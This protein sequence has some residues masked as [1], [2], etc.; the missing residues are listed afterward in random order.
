V[1]IAAILG[2]IAYT[3][4]AQKKVL[5]AEA[6]AR[7]APLPPELNSSSEMY[8]W[9]ER[10]T[11]NGNRITADIKASDVKELKDSPLVE[12]KNVT[13][14][15]P[16]KEGDT[17]NL[18]ESAAASFFK[19][20][21][22]L[23]SE[24]DVEITLHKPMVGE[25][26]HPPTIIRSSGVT[27]DS[28]IGRAETERPST[29]KFERGEGA[30]T[31]GFYDPVEHRLLMKSDVRVDWKPLGPHAKLMKIEAGSLQY[32]ETESQIWLNPWGRLTRENTVV[33]GQDVT[34]HLEENSAG[35]KVI[36]KIDTTKAHGSDSYP[37]RKLQYSAG[38][39]W[40]EFN[41]E[42]QVEKIIAQTN[43]QLVSTSETA[44][45][46][47]TADHVEMNFTAQNG[48]SVLSS[49]NTSGNSVVTSK[50]VAGP[51]RQ[52]GETHVLRSDRLEMKMR[53]GGR[54]LASV[55]TDAPG[56]L[57][58]LP[59]LPIQRHRLL[60]GGNMAIAY[61]PQNR[62]ESFRSTNV[63]TRT[64]PNADERKRNRAVSVTTSREI[65]ARFDPKTGQMASIEQSGDFAYD[66]GD[67][68][69]RAAKATLENGEDVILLE[70]GTR[71]SDATGSTSADHIRMDQRTGN[72]T[73]EGHVY[74]SRL[75]EKDPK[76][77]SQL[78]SG[79]QPLQAQ[80][81]KMDSTNR[82]RT[83]HYEGGVNMWQGADRIQA[84]TIDID[85]EKR[86]LVADG[87]VATNLWETP[88]DDPKAPAAKKK[89]E[90]VLTV[91]H[92]QH[93][94]YTD[95]N[96]LAVYTGGVL[97][98]RPSLRVKGATL[99]AVLADSSGDSR[100]E[101]ATADGAVEVVHD[102]RTAGRTGTSE[103]A[104]YYTNEQKIILRGGEP[105]MVERK[106]NGRVDT[107][108]GSEL[109]YYANDD[110][111]LVNGSSS[112]PG[113]SQTQRK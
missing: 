23:Y 27:L 102:S 94:V 48:D 53:D 106:P 88:K 39:L 84:K 26:K 2:G 107:T 3:Y 29:F 95:E 33:E 50:P 56:T 87:D 60:E 8:H 15:L 113:Q 46:D 98:T 32:R 85:R 74:S 103:H 90:P 1:A 16:S 5:L 105:K 110:R 43:A 93:L 57:E 89:T 14:Q 109:T 25:S 17:Y 13:I 7:P 101:K 97:L 111:L 21:H 71:V 65:L 69:A 63:R 20:D 77:N 34:V 100:L 96:R 49:V 81:A 76:K 12:L 51:N 68:K 18:V 62:I 4:R 31:G 40:V 73:A 78:L 52:P 61:G 6:P 24:G 80:A 82:N 41:D 108:E 70:S 35:H 47:V 10:D 45:T 54:E 86:T 75:P 58:F 38:A 22:R 67:R 112:R 91:V 64:E 59:N 37:N 36:R 66:E 44:E 19:S 28:A 104:E 11:K 9:V 92:S 83:V 79:D 55:T 72:F 30:A 42:G 99:S